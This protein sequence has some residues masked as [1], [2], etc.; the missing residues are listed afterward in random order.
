M[1]PFGRPPEANALTE[2]GQ[3]EQ[4]MPIDLDV[5]EL[6]HLMESGVNLCGGR[7]TLALPPS[8]DRKPPFPKNPL[9]P[10]VGQRPSHNMK[11]RYL[12]TTCAPVR[13]DD[14]FLVM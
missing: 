14:R 13:H 1:S 3:H 11:R 9:R 5:V 2:L 6:M 7:E 10:V 12:C 4:I 8:L